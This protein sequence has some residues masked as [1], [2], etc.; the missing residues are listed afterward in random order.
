VHGDSWE[1]FP[2][3]QRLLVHL[4]GIG[5]EV[6]AAGLALLLRGRARRGSMLRLGLLGF[7]ACNLVHAG[8]YLTAGAFD[9]FGDGW[10]LHRMLGARSQ[11]FVGVA[12]LLTLLL[13]ARLASEIARSCAWLARRGRVRRL[14]MLSV[15]VAAAGLGHATLTASEEL[16]RSPVPRLGGGRARGRGAGL[17]GGRDRLPHDAGR[18]PVT[19]GVP[20]CDTPGGGETWGKTRPAG[21]RAVRG[22]GSP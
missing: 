1:T 14:V 19:P 11:L 5:A 20:R 21:R 18:R 7:A 15:A 8:Y 4:A 2:E 13:A 3:S 17:P 12:V 9:G 16:I 10:L 22:P 6:L